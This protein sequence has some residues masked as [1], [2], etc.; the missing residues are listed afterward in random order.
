MQHSIQTCTDLL[1]VYGLRVHEKKDDVAMVSS[2]L[3]AYLER[4]AAVGVRRLIRGRSHRPLWSRS[5][6]SRRAHAQAR[7]VAC[8][9]ERPQHRRA[10][11]HHARTVTSSVRSRPGV[12]DGQQEGQGEQG[13]HLHRR[14][15]ADRRTL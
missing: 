7:R 1:T 13:E 12:R 14:I 3:Y 15:A 4:A 11:H 6:Q 10:S 8:S 9:T 2:V 5:R